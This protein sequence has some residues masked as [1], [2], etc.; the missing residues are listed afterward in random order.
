[1]S[2]VYSEEPFEYPSELPPLAVG[3]VRGQA[4]SVKPICGEY[5]LFFLSGELAGREKSQ[6]IS[7]SENLGPSEGSLSIETVLNKY[8]VG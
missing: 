1:M 4:W 5:V 2:E 8:G 6:V 7:K 3:E